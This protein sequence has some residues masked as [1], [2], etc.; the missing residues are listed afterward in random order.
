[1]L[2]RDTSSHSPPPKGGTQAGKL[3]NSSG[4]YMM[5]RG[6]GGGGI[7]GCP[8]PPKGAGLGRVSA[9]LVSRPPA[10][11]PSSP[12]RRVK[13]LR[14]TRKSGCG[15]E[16]KG[17]QPRHFGREK[18]RKVSWQGSPRSWGGATPCVRDSRTRRG[19][20]T[21]HRRGISTSHQKKRK[22]G[23]GAPFWLAVL[24]DI[25]RTGSAWS[26]WQGGAAV[27]QEPRGCHRHGSG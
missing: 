20:S 4:G 12:A 22:K 23:L 11:I 25:G 19:I 26:F 8:Y 24:A 18:A 16:K 9:S 6:Q 2:R 14:R 21:P 13:T 1:M 7:I 27:G 5:T 10:T 3:S 17:L 15:N